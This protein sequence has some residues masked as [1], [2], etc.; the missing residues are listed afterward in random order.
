[1]GEHALQRPPSYPTET[2]ETLRHLDRQILPIPPLLPRPDEVAQVRIA[3]QA[4]RQVCVRG[5]VPTLSKGHH[6]VVRV[7][8]HCSVHGPQFLSRF[9]SAVSIQ[10]VYPF[11][12][13]RSRDRASTRRTH[14]FGEVLIVRAGIEERQR[15]SAQQGMQVIGT[16]VQRRTHAR[17]ELHLTHPWGLGGD[18]VASGLPGVK[19]AVQYMDIRMAQVFQEPETTCRTRAGDAFIEDHGFIQIDAALLEQVF[20]H[21][22]E[23]G[24]GFGAGIVQRDAKQIEMHRARYPALGIGGGG[25]YVDDGQVGIPKPAVQLLWRPEQVRVSIVFGGHAVTSLVIQGAGYQRS[26]YSDHRP[27]R[28]GITSGR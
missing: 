21:P 28:Y 16:D 15:V 14:V 2:S 19:T 5:A 9:E 23:R 26:S 17:L 11:Q 6:R 10:I 1:M 18:W 3:E 7:N 24:Q 20:Y 13:H 4:Q 22:H 25:A 27:L 8:T 12:V